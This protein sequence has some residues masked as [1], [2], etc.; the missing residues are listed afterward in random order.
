MNVQE[1]YSLAR[2]AWVDKY[3]I[4]I[5]DRLETFDRAVDKGVVVGFDTDREAVRL[6]AGRDMCGRDYVVSVPI[7][8]IKVK[9]KK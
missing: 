2:P 4:Q 6:K 8:K 9:A 7:D 1:F 3:G 5:G